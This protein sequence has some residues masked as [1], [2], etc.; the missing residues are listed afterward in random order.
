LSSPQTR[1]KPLKIYRILKIIAAIE[2]PTV[3][4]KILVHLGLPTRTPPRSFNLFAMAWFYN[5][6]AMSSGSAPE[7]KISLDRRLSD[8]VNFVTSFAKHLASIMATSSRFFRPM[9]L[10]IDISADFQYFSLLKR[11]R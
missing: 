8:A 3:M 6:T 4:T 9:I 7:L 1:R 2:D 11:D 5:D 10:A